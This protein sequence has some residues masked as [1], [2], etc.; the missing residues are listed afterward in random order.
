MTIQWVQLNGKDLS[1]YSNKKNEPVSLRKHQSPT[2]QQS[3]FERCQCD[4]HLSEFLPTRWRQ[5]SNGTDMEQNYVTVTLRISSYFLFSCVND[6]DRLP[7][8]RVTVT[9]FRAISM[10]AGFR[11]HLV[12]KTLIMFIAVISPKYA[13]LIS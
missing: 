10:P 6:K 3:V 11:R 4:K 2:Y 7:E 13:L 12:G 5:K 8:H 9:L 1:C